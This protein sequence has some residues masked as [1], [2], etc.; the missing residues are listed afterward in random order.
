MVSLPGNICINLHLFSHDKF[1]I[2]AQNFLK[3]Q[4]Y[5]DLPLKPQMVDPEPN[6]RC[7][8]IILLRIIIM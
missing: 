1:L 3:M 2:T 7:E 8:I 6:W 5:N 4:R